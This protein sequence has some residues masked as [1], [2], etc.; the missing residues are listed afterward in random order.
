MGPPGG[1]SITTP[2]FIPDE[3][4]L[5]ALQTAVLRGVEH[6][7]R[8]LRD[9]GPGAGVAGAAVV[10]RGAARGRGPIHLYRRNFLHAKHLSIDDDIALI[11]TSNMDIRS[12]VLN[13]ELV[14]V[15]YDPGVT[16]HLR[17]EQEAVFREL[18]SVD[19]RGLEAQVLREEAGPTPGP[20]VQPALVNAR[21]QPAAR[22]PSSLPSPDRDDTMGHRRA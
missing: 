6:P 7:S 18:L 11:G 12:F 20:V 9:G 10:L 19:A 15:I 17:T 4:L 5:Q 16:G 2:Y 14:L 22:S 13:A 1:S 3:P 8:A 21:G